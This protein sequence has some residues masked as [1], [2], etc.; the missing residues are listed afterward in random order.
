MVSDEE[1]RRRLDDPDDYAR[2]EIRIE[3]EGR[4]RARERR[5]AVRSGR[6]CDD[7]TDDIWIA[8]S[9][10]VECGLSRARQ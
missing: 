10:P 5:P 9:A 2:L 6:D 8:K 7:E 1:S 4:A 3:I